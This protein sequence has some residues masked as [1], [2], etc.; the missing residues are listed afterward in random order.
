ML[1]QAMDKLEGLVD[2]FL[3]E[4]ELKKDAY[5]KFFKDNE[6]IGFDEAER[7]LLEKLKRINT[8]AV[9]EKDSH[10][11]KEEDI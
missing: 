10:D 6:T 5:L 4:D 2:A 3:E 11:Y 1:S 7:N 9:S 8:D